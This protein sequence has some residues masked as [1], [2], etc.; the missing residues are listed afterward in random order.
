MPP[1]MR[2]IIGWGKTANWDDSN[3]YLDGVVAEWGGGVFVG[4]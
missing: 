4:D 3:V 1:S 2:V